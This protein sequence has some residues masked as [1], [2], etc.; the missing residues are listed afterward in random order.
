[1]RF[2]AA[3]LIDYEGTVRARVDPRTPGA[4]GLG[5][6]QAAALLARAHYRGRAQREGEDELAAALAAEPVVNAGR[7]IR[8]ARQQGGQPCA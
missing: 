7:L 2:V 5:P 8:P 6:V 1:M 3:L 4:D